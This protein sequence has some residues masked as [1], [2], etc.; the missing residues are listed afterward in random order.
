MYHDKLL[1]VPESLAQLQIFQAKH[2]TLVAGHFGFNK[3]M[4]LM[5]HG[6]W[7]P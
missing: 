3:T 2:D 5:S 4:E 6:Y 7:L 1:Y